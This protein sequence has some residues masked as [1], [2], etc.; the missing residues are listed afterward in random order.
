MSALLLVAMAFWVHRLHR[1]T[2]DDRGGA[3]GCDGEVWLASQARPRAM[4]ASA[5]G[6]DRSSIT[7]VCGVQQ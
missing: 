5:R 1:A 2:T 4:R 3:T 6:L 7:C